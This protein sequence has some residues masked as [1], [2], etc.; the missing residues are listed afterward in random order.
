MRVPSTSS[1]K[2][3]PADPAILVSALQA[4]PMYVQLLGK[5]M[6]ADPQRLGSPL[7]KARIYFFEAT[8]CRSACNGA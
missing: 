1:K 3:L 5:A 4:W 7:L 2:E 8:V 6:M